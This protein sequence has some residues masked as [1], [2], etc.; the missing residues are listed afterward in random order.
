[1]E[2]RLWIATAK[3]R[4]S[5]QWKNEEISW[6][7][8]IQKLKQPYR[9]KETMAEYRKMGKKEQGAIKDVGGFVAGKLKEGRRLDEN[10]ISRSMITLDVDYAPL[11]LWDDME[12]LFGYAVVMY[13]THNH[14]DDH[15]RYRLILPLI[16][17]VTPDEYQ[18]IA[19]KIAQEIG[20]DY[21]DDTTYQ[22]SR[23]MYWPSCCSDGKYVFRVS[24]DAPWIDPDEI[25]SSYED[26]RDMSFWPMSS[27]VLEIHK[28][29]AKKQ[30]DPLAKDGLIGAFCRTYSI[31]EAIETFL[32]D[33][34]EC[35]NREDRYTYIGGSTVGGLV[36]YEDRFAYSNHATDPTSMHLCN[37]FDLVRIHKFR[38]L[39]NDVKSDTPVNKLPSWVA[40]MDL[41][42]QDERTKT[43]LGEE[44]LERA[45]ID[46]P[47]AEECDTSWLAKMETDKRGNYVTTTDNIVLILANDPR[48]KDSIGGIDRYEQKPVKLGNLPWWGHNKKD[49]GWKDEDDAALRYLLEKDYKIVAKG[50]VDDAIMYTHEQNAFNPV[51]DYLD[52]LTWDGTERL[53]MLFI[54][55]LG[56][57]DNDYTRAVTRK[58]FTAAIARA[59]EPGCK[60]DY[61][62]VLVGAQGIGKSHLLTIMGGDWFTDSL[63]SLAGKEGY[64]ALHGSWIVEMAELTAT[65][66]TDVERIKQFISQRNDRYRKAYAKRVT[67]NPRKCVFFGTTNDNEFLRDY[68]GNRRFWPLDTDKERRTKD[69]F[70]DLPKERD[71]IWAEAKYRYEQK[72]PLYL[73][74]DLLKA[75]ETVQDKYTYKSPKEGIIQ[76]YLERR[77]PVNWDELDCFSRIA[78]MESG[79]E[80]TV[81]RQ[82]VCALELWCE[83]FNGG[84]GTLTNADAREINGILDRMEG[85]RKLPNPV[86]INKEYGKQRAYEK[87]ETK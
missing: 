18:A 20:I 15:P 82:R 7:Q 34:Y 61:M 62:P 43:L 63:T 54:D 35:T 60:Y 65:R 87:L 10:V 50:K 29:S 73:E 1:M 57:T 3:S 25:L 30:G 39:D 47:D 41:I 40:M 66:K 8:F 31:Q 48:L 4:W 59:Y 9:T 14:S 78:W 77:L 26:W 85:W 53:D 24:E 67:D 11:D 72:E 86:R 33:V 21:F 71:Q 69:L 64:E 19:R 42:G 81:E 16:R 27:R 79:N 45:L 76:D 51:T 58:A 74:G 13:S 38:E 22:S 5:K 80:G 68:T 55:Y 46:F 2:R 36:I 83:L 70:K 28:R 23:L 32:N 6:Q 84:K 17:D 37:A 75:A 52:T 12:M 44:R 49:N 56:S